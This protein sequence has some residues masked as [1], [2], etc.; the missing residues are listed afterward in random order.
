M[1]LSLIILTTFT[2]QTIMT[3]SQPTNYFDSGRILAV[4]NQLLPP[5]E[6]LDVPYFEQG[7]TNWCFETSLSMVIQYYGTR[8]LPADIASGLSAG[9]NDGVDIFDMFLGQVDSYL[10]ELPE[11]SF[12]HHIEKWDFS[13]YA[14][15]IDDKTPVIVSTFGI[16]GHTMVVVGYL[17]EADGRFLLVH[18][19]SGFLSRSCLGNR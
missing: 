6:Q 13:K 7:N 3:T 11:F 2:A 5:T 8:V 14:Q 12:Q 9:P 4:E 18:D 19:P 16:P 1:Y 17:D 15:M 10:S